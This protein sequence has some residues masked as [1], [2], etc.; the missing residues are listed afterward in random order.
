MTHYNHVIILFLKSPVGC[1]KW[2]HGSPQTEEHML[3]NPGT[4]QYHVPRGSTVPQRTQHAPVGQDK[5]N[6]GTDYLCPVYTVHLNQCKPVWS[7]HMHY[8]VYRK[9]F[10]KHIGCVY[11]VV[12]SPDSSSTLQEEGLGTKLFGTFTFLL[13]VYTQLL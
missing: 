10:P 4:P 1:Q 8:V 3:G 7:N 12:L 2:S 5:G 11:T 6:N 9:Q 13:G